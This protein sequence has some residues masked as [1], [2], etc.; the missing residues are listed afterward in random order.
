MEGGGGLGAVVVEME[1]RRGEG[2]EGWERGRRDAMRRSN[3]ISLELSSI[4]IIR[5]S[6]IWISL[7]L[8]WKEGGKEGSSRAHPLFR[9]DFRS[10]PS[11]FLP[12][13]PLPEN[14]IDLH[15]IP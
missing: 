6:L 4:H 11:F 2:G 1:E 14:S 8:L 12:F 13:I 10:S 3:V 9:I 15:P 5:R 7:P